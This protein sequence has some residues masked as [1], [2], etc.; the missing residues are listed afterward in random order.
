M[1]DF[2][3]L[4]RP[5]VMAVMLVAQTVWHVGDRVEAGFMGSSYSYKFGEII[6]VDGDRYKVHF[7]GYDVS[8]ESW[9]PVSHVRPIVAP[10]PALATP[11]MAA[12]TTPAP[13][14]QMPACE[15]GMVIRAGAL[16]YD[17]KIIEFSKTT[18]LY[19]VQYVTGYKGD[20]EFVPPTGLKTCSA[21][22]IAP[23]AE[24][25][26]VGV[27]QLFNGGGGAWQKNPTTNTWKV[28]GLDAAGG[29]SIKQDDFTSPI[30]RCVTCSVS[31]RSRACAHVP[32]TIARLPLTR[33]P[34]LFRQSRSCAA[35]ALVHV[36][37]MH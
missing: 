14:N 13:G 2:V 8:Y 9:V 22:T 26:F 21:P 23:V 32:H 15:I 4:V 10:T 27:W 30:N 12:A 20:I 5:I 11:P 18:G 25:W 24:K 1:S 31:L 33:A 28:I 3:S 29:H 17:A 19:K 7:D 35:R 36:R 16:N 37:N 6:A 34:A